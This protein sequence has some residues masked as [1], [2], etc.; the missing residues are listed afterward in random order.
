MGTYFR[1][2]STSFMRDENLDGEETDNT[3]I[4]LRSCGYW[5]CDNKQTLKKPSNGGSYQKPLVLIHKNLLL[6]LSFF[7]MYS[8]PIFTLTTP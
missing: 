1:G 8:I 3:L 2:R 6:K 5:Q 4:V 7:F